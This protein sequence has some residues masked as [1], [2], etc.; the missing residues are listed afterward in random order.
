MMAEQAVRRY[1]VRANAQQER[2]CAQIHKAGLCPSLCNKVGGCF[3]PNFDPT[4]EAKRKVFRCR[5]ALSLLVQLQEF[6]KPQNL[7]AKTALDVVSKLGIQ[8]GVVK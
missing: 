8:K 2:V 6:G 5:E 7:S 1:S 4:C 3:L